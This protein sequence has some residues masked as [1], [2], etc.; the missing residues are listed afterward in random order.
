MRGVIS[1]WMMKD[2]YTSGV[3]ILYRIEKI[4][5]RRYWQKL[6]GKVIM[7]EWNEEEHFPVYGKMFDLPES[8]S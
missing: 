3:D 4:L 1:I 2:C 8:K 5:D 7:V 6:I